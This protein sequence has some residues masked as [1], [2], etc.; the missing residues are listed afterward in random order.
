M[1]GWRFLSLV[2]IKPNVD[3]NKSQVELTYSQYC[4]AAMVTKRPR[5]S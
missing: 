3:A 2:Y 4:A 5:A 1:V